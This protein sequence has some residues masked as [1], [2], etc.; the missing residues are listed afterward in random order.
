VVIVCVHIADYVSEK[1]Q[2][3]GKEVSQEYHKQRAIH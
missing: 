2:Q 1:A 3:A